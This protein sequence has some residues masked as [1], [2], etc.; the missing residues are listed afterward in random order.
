MN[1]P[2]TAETPSIDWLISVDDHVIEPPGVW[3]HR[4]PSKWRD[5]APRSET[6]DDGQVWVYDGRRLPVEGLAAAAGRDK[7]E[8]S[9]LLNRYSDMR[10]GCYDPYERV[11]DM[12]LD[13]ILA[14]MCFPTMPRFCGQTFLEASDKDLALLCV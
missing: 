1:E 11:K 13:R 7:R 10:P 14:S 9:T 5:D 4:L 6:D 3:T 8:Y 12:D 2:E